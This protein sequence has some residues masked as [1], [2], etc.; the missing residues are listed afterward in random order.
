M[1]RFD[2]H[3]VFTV[4]HFLQSTM[5]LFVSDLWT[6]SYVLRVLLFHVSSS[7]SLPCI[8]YCWGKRSF[9]L[10]L[11]DRK[12]P[13]YKSVAASSHF[14]LLLW[15]KQL[16]YDSSTTFYIIASLFTYMKWSSHIGTK[17]RGMRLSSRLIFI[18]LF[19]FV[20]FMSILC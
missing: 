8:K 6:Y 7:P 2:N 13:S 14:I 19:E 17:A 18:M 4:R 9:F 16:R 12:K 20:C 5:P 10:S 1:Y 11:I 15:K 3:K